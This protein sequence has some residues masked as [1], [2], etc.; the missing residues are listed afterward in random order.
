MLESWLK[1]ELAWIPYILCFSFL[2]YQVE[3]T[4]RQTQY[5]PYYCIN[6]QQLVFPP[7]QYPN[8]LFIALGTGSWEGSLLPV[9]EGLCRGWVVKV[10]CFNR[11]IEVFHI[12]TIC[13]GLWRVYLWNGCQ[14]KFQK[15]LPLSWSF[16]RFFR[17]PKKSLEVEKVMLKRGGVGRWGQ[18]GQLSFPLWHYLCDLPLLPYRNRGALWGTWLCPSFCS[19][20]K[21]APGEAGCSFTECSKKSMA[22]TRSTLTGRHCLGEPA[23]LSEIRLPGPRAPKTRFADWWERTD[24]MVAI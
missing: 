11:C 23:C 16:K 20:V 22:A 8:I 19:D 15:G 24:W 10:G 5:L 18:L 1:A 6:K 3:I 13:F 17:S 12:H 9:L 2:I 4:N 7:A 21:G 14:G